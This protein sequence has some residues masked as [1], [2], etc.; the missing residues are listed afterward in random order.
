MQYHETRKEQEL[1]AFSQKF[2]PAPYYDAHRMN[3]RIAWTASFVC[4]LVSLGLAYALA[5]W[6]FALLLPAWAN[7]G[8]VGQIPLHLLSGCFLAVLEYAKRESLWDASKRYLTTRTARV[9]APEVILLACLVASVSASTW[10]ARQWVHQSQTQVADLETEF[11]HVLDST[12]NAENAAVLARKA[13]H[14]AFLQ[15]VSWKGR[16]NIHNPAVQA[17][18]QAYYADLDSITARSSRIW[19]AWQT[20]YHQERAEALQDR[21]W[22]VWALMSA[23]LANEL[24]FLLLA[25]FA[26]YY[27]WRCV[28]EADLLHAAPTHQSQ[29]GQN[30]AVTPPLRTIGFLPTTARQGKKGR[31]HRPGKHTLNPGQRECKHCGTVYTYKQIHQ[32]FCS[33]AC[34]I[35]HWQKKN[36]HP[37]APK[38]AHR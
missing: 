16:V 38:R 12:Q 19:H 30:T 34:R 14:E 15:R 5:Y 24:L 28:V 35:E 2:S 20:G 3:Y 23:S 1:Q 31:E 11:Q 4:N 13:E 33:P 7:F 37:L 26:I 36:N 29:N 27:Q 8:L 6:L 10:G 32:K 18:E 22:L 21:S 9:G 25:G 17:A